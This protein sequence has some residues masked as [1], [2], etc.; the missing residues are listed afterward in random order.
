MGNSSNKVQSNKSSVLHSLPNVSGSFAGKS[1]QKNLKNKQ[2][3]TTFVFGK[4]KPKKAPKPKMEPKPI[5]GKVNPQDHEEI[6]QTKAN[7]EIKEHWTPRVMKT[8]M[9]NTHHHNYKIVKMKKYSAEKATYLVVDKENRS[10]ILTQYK[11]YQ[12][13][14]INAK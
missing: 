13:S 10:K 5:K 6:P 4:K 1:P 14:E 7:L 11:F 12:N 8:L 3:F 9:P 2:S